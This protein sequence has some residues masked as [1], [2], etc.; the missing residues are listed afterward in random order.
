MSS[1]I[2]KRSYFRVYETD[3]PKPR[4]G[5]CALMS[6]MA[7]RSRSHN[8][9]L[10][11]RTIAKFG[12]SSLSPSSRA[13]LFAI[14]LS[15][16]LRFERHLASASCNFSDVLFILAAKQMRL[17]DSINRK[18]RLRQRQEVDFPRGCVARFQYPLWQPANH[19]LSST[20]KYTPSDSSKVY[21]RSLTSLIHF[22]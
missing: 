10:H 16:G 9:Q 18:L 11:E 7:T 2:N 6:H 3:L 5:K 21:R 8:D 13:S 17:T 22:G 1:R 19:K 15:G 12:L 20:E 4:F 14:C